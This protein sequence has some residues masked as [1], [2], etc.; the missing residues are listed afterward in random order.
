MAENLK[1]SMTAGARRKAIV[2]QQGHRISYDEINASS[3]KSIMDG[4]DRAL[5]RVYGFTPLH[6]D[7]LIN[8]DVKYRMGGSEDNIE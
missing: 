3:S 5:A 2:T 1:R 6:L 8:Y 7:L 4:I